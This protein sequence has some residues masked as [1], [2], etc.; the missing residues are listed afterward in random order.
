[1][2]RGTPLGRQFAVGS[3]SGWPA[4]SA[5]ARF[6]KNSRAHGRKGVELPS[7]GVFERLL[8]SATHTPEILGTSEATRTSRL[9]GSPV[10]TAGGAG[11]LWARAVADSRVIPAISPTEANTCERCMWCLATL[12]IFALPFCFAAASNGEV[13]GDIVVPNPILICPLGDGPGAIRER[14]IRFLRRRAEPPCPREEC[15]RR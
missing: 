12:V 10:I 13:A 14:R 4:A 1:M 6:S 3:N 2:I 7:A 5:A 8:V 11:A 15:P 9:A